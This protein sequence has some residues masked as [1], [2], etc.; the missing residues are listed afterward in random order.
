MASY[1][2]HVLALEAQHQ[3]ERF[4]VDWRARRDH[5]QTEYDAEVKNEE[6]ATRKAIAAVEAE[7]HRNMQVVAANGPQTVAMVEEVMSTKKELKIKELESRLRD[8]RAKMQAHY[9]K[10][11]LDHTAKFSDAIMDRLKPLAANSP[12]S[13]T[14]TSS[15]RRVLHTHRV[16][17]ANL[18]RLQP[19]IQPPP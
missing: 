3:A 18:P 11:L 19:A 2:E 1:K 13:E 5:L 10:Q 6:Y 17:S 9:E 15:S 4:Y 16:E 8:T 7:F 14:N 12:V